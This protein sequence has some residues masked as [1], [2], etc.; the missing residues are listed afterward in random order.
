MT[1]QRGA[2]TEARARG[3]KL[4]SGWRGQVRAA[5]DRLLAQEVCPWKWGGGGLTQR[6]Q[7]TRPLGC[8]TAPW[9]S[10]DSACT[11]PGICMSTC[12]PPSPSLCE[13]SQPQPRT[14]TGRKPHSSPSRALSSGRR[15][16]TDWFPGQRGV[17]PVGWERKGRGYG[18]DSLQ[19]QESQT[20]LRTEEPGGKCHR[21][22]LKVNVP[23]A[24]H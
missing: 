1:F 21:S 3:V 10:E 23:Q 8:V 18:A 12:D 16:K 11:V 13:T 20:H 15:R 24:S 9:A 19:G 4:L 14:Q 5:V 22:L 7:G 17:G 6:P 2:G